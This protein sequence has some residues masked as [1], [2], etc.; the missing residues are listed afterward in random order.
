MIKNRNN[1]VDEKRLIWIRVLAGRKRR[2][3]KSGTGLSNKKGE[4]EG[5][6]KE[7]LEWKFRRLWKKKLAMRDRSLENE[8]RH[9]HLM[10]FNTLGRSKICPIS[11]PS[12]LSAMMTSF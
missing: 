2:I 7:V 3:K 5:E 9:K 11:I 12:I 4:R 10:N 1:K 6:K 8:V